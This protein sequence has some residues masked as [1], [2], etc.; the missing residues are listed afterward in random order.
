VGG[1]V[2]SVPAV[3]G[4][5]QRRVEKPWGHEVWWAQSDEYAGKLLVV[6]AGH[7]LS[8]QVHREKDESS[9][10]LSGR[11]R[12]TYGPSAD[13]L[14]EQEIGSGESWRIEP[15]IVHSIE[16]LEDSV[17][18]E[19]STPHLDDVVRLEDRYGRGIGKER[20]RETFPQE[21]RN[22]PR[23]VRPATAAD[24]EAICSI[25]NAALAERGSTFETE[26]RSIE[27]FADRIEDS[28][29]PFLVAT[30]P[31]VIGWAGLAPYSTRPCYAGI[32]ECS[33]YVA[34]AA[35]GRGVG[36]SLTEALA[37][38][39]EGSGF[40]KLIGK[41]FTDN[42]ASVRLIERCGFRQVGLHHRHG[43]LDGEWRDVLVVERLLQAS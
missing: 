15:G 23:N 32:A 2:D 12:L 24:A 36:T 6:D 17:V 14:A 9:Y 16:A 30:A 21:G 19:V 11:L 26:P 10:L 33:V 27:D 25:Y 5:E 38:A 31:E 28:R 7:R 3:Q 1:A 8:L 41:V 43:Q 42:T 29:F 13:E 18:L 37:G 20:N 35:R 4:S 34:A 22:D 39:A 40:H